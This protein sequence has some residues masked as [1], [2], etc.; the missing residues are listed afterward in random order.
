MR[1]STFTFAAADGFSLFVYRW[2]PDKAPKAAV[3]LAHGLAEHSGRY[4]RLAGALTRA[5]YAV[6]AADHR[7]HGRTARA[8]EDLGF[9]AEREGWRKCVDDLWHLHNRIA[10]DHSGL[11]L[12]LIGHSMGS[13]MAQQFISEHG[14]GLA[15]A[16]L[17]GSGGRPLRLT[18]A[19]RL[20][21]RMERLRLGGRGRSALINSLTFGAFNKPFEPARTPFDW[22]SRDHAEVDKF[23][24]DPLCGVPSSLQLSIDV[25]DALDDVTS[26]SRQSRIPKPLPI[27][28]IAGTRDPVSAGTRTLSQLLAAYR[29]AGLERVTYRFYPGARHELFNETNRDEVTRDVIDWANGVIGGRG[30]LRPHHFPSTADRPWA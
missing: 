7:G 11:P 22:L 6:Y 5:G 26:V 21:A 19:V 17:S 30:K 4:A 28:I 3:Q 16:V 2:L 24:A 1:S 10:A 9:F 25:L 12:L 23:V 29:A 15:G 20:L 13:F 18:A 14:R 27:H 8:P